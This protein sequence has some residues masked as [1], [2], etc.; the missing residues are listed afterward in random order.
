MLCP[1]DRVR[2][3]EYAI[4]DVLVHAKN[5]EKQGKSVI[6]LNIGD[7]VK[8]GFKTPS[9]IQQ[10]LVKAIEDGNNWYSPSEGLSELR[11]AISDKERKVNQVEISPE[12]VIVTSGVSEGILMAMAA[13][14]DKGSEVLVPGPTYPPYISYTR[15]F[16]GY[17]IEYK[18]IE[19]DS[20][21]PDIDDIRS[22]I[23][24][25]TKCIVIVNPNNPTGALY[26]ESDL[27]DIINIAG[28]HDLLLISDEIY[29]RF[30][31][32][33]PFIS[34]AAISRDVPVIG[35]NG[36]SK[37]YCMTG[38]RL[39][40]IYFHDT[41]GSLTSLEENIAKMCRIRLSANTPV[42]MAAIQ[43]LA[44]PQ[45]HI[46]ENLEKLKKRRDYAVRRVNEIRDV[47]CT[48]PDGSFYLFPR[49]FPRAQC[50]NDEEFVL[51]VLQETG[52]LFVH[53]S[54]FGKTYGPGHF[55]AVFLPPLEVLAEAFDRLER[56][57]NKD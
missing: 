53:G 5:L 3:I 11:E 17:P 48:Y 22:K 55:R 56:F 6:Y 45:D 9:H 13:I 18:T 30:T 27:K 49:F 32:G 42:Q 19:E 54:G 20:W 40:Y 29:D 10:A 46:L 43:A 39:G 36:F 4:R 47:E 21:K 12:N 50:K 41:K 37:A 51:T 23:T 44:G 15:F 24:S 33:N 31:Y 16:D 35:L 25:S 8:Y 1:T 34:T 14:V 38:W 52:L 26:A 7:P 2:N 28:E 57:M